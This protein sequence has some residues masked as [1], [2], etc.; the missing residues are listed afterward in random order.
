MHY[1]TWNL[2]NNM[3]HVLRWSLILCRCKIWLF[4]DVSEVKRRLWSGSKRWSYVFGGCRHCTILFFDL[5]H[6]VNF[7]WKKKCFAATQKVMMW[8]QAMTLRFWRMQ[9]MYHTVLWSSYSV[10]FDLKI[11]MFCKD[12]DGYDVEMSDDLKFLEDADN[13][14]FFFWSS[15]SANLNFLWRFAITQTVIM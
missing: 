4:F 13:I 15:Y 6:N 12:T 10:N 2:R 7:D 3:M 14:L 11:R 9:T 1:F 5:C 8:K